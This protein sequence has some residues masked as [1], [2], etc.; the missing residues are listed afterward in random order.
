[1]PK[2]QPVPIPPTFIQKHFLA[3]VMLAHISLVI[4]T[5]PTVQNHPP[6]SVTSDCFNMGLI[7]TWSLA[8][9]EPLAAAGQT[10]WPPSP[11]SGHSPR[12]HPSGLLAASVGQFLIRLKLPSNPCRA[13]SPTGPKHLLLP[14]LTGGPLTALMW[15]YHGRG[16]PCARPKSPQ[17]AF[18]LLLLFLLCHHRC[19]GLGE[20]ITAPS[21]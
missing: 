20:K 14:L 1:M 5:H 10:G 19:P 8:L 9:L 2:Y 13:S 12:H 17:F 11:A 7:I 4:Q 3:T 6:L 21:R 16:N 15:H 18:L